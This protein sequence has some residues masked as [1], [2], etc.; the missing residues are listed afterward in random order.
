MNSEAD[1][2]FRNE[3][4][5]RFQASGEWHRA[6]TEY[7]AALAALDDAGIGDHLL[8]SVV[9]SNYGLLEWSRGDFKRA[10]DHL[11]ESLHIAVRVRA[12]PLDIALTRDNLG[13]IEVELARQAG[14]L[15]GTGYVNAVAEQHLSQAEEYYS[16]ARKELRRGLPGAAEEYVTHLLNSTDLAALRE[17]LAAVDRLTS[18]AMGLVDNGRVSDMTRWLVVAA[19]GEALLDLNQPR[20]ALD[21]MAP[22]FSEL[23]TRLTIGQVPTR[24]L[25]TLLKAAYA[26]RDH[27]YAEEVA[28]TIITIDNTQL[29]KRLAQCS[30]AQ[31]RHLFREFSSRT[32][33]ILGRCLP[34]GPVPPW[35]Y[36]LVLN[37]K[38]VL[39]ER[40]GSAWLE[41]RR[42]EGAGEQLLRKVRDLRSEAAGLDIDGSDLDT[43]AA[44]RR[45]HDDVQRRLAQAEARLVTE[46][47]PDHPHLPLFDVDALRAV[48]APDTVVLDFVVIRAPD[49]QDDYFMFAVGGHGPIRGK[50]IG[51]VPEVDERLLRL[52]HLVGQP[53]TDETERAAILRDLAPRLFDDDDLLAHNIVVVPSGTWARV[54]FCLL[55]DAHGR[56]LIDRHTV[57]SVPSARWLISQARREPGQPAGPPVVV[58]DPDFDMGCAEQVSFL[59]RTRHSP[60][61]HA[62]H[63]T[64]AIAGRLRVAPFVG[65]HA[66]RR[67]LLELER[68][69]VLHIV[70][71]ATFIEAIRSMAEQAEPKSYVM[72]AVG[73][74]VVTEEVTEEEGLGWAPAGPSAVSLDDRARHKRRVRWWR[75]IGPASQFSRST[76]LLA[77][78]NAWLAGVATPPAVGTGFLTAAEFALLDLRSTR[79]VVLAACETGVGA[80][81]YADGSL[82]GLRTA[83]L[84]AGASWCV[85]SQW[86]V[87]DQATASLFATF[88]DHFTTGSD[89]G[90]SL[91]AAQLAIRATYPDPYF[92]AAWTADGAPLVARVLG[93]S[94]PSG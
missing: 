14:L 1:A 93:A 65:R 7:Q 85:S 11:L 72:R 82:I 69:E 63:E 74:T 76:L 9:H 19:R 90:R 29:V 45:R 54:P 79:L 8:R 43:I 24:G 39:A 10:R 21:F 51:P 75:E 44:A 31:A 32:G 20:H 38:G 34:D 26:V 89:P 67:C 22:W 47:S 58:G 92:W 41:A 30:E 16:H 77:G 94:A 62:G 15:R 64:R 42:D 4:G 71:H 3:N 91:R 57:T 83:A 78:C 56:P 59:L 27:R 49:D 46:I 73:G 35:L 60:L 12:V 87:D 28:N 13:G 5:E 33:L 66:T 6:E 70:A 48:L 84:A 17:D 40:Q 81:D 23:L 53:P 80:V 52:C 86:K 61:A 88:Y 37:R 2:A 18:E 68:P 55:P 25:P 36:E 50:V